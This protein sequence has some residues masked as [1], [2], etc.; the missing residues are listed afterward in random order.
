[1]SERICVCVAKCTSDWTFLVKYKHCDDFM[2]KLLWLL[3]WNCTDKM[4]LDNINT[5]VDYGLCICIF[6]LLLC[7]F[8]V[9][10]YRDRWIKDYQCDEQADGQREL[11]QRCTVSVTVV[12]RLT[13][14]M[15]VWSLYGG[16]YVVTL[17][18]CHCR[19]HGSTLR[20]DKSNVP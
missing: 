3:L 17:Q 4:L 16:P 10:F 20:C 12:K 13:V 19:Q 5:V 11:L 15:I 8:F 9:I 1:M 18:R 6:L 7:Y 2:C 14:F